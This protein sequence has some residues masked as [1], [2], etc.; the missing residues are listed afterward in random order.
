MAIEDALELANQLGAVARQLEGQQG[1]QPGAGAVYDTPAAVSALEGALRRY[2]EQ[3]APR[4]MQVAEQSLQVGEHAC[5]SL[6][7]TIVWRLAM[8]WQ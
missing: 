7:S 8:T 3:R 1:Q 2:E 6:L 5:N 4:A